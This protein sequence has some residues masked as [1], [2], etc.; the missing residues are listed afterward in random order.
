MKNLC[1]GVLVRASAIFFVGLLIIQ[2][3]CVT[4]PIQT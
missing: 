4:L 3:F 1:R 2:D